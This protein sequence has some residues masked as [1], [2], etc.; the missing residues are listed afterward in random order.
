M[1]VLVLGVLSAKHHNCG[2]WQPYALRHAVVL[3]CFCLPACV[4]P[5]VETCSGFWLLLFARVWSAV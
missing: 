5:Q 2:S 1:C 4:V 3:D